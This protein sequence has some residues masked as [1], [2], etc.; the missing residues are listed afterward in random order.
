MTN[1]ATTVSESLSSRRSIRAFQDRPVDGVLLRTILEKASRSPSGGN[2]QPWHLYVIGGGR[3]E[4]LK[5]VM[6]ERLKQAPDGEDREYDVYP[7]NL[8][9]PYRDRR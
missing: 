6:R 5:A 2:L 7:P 4:E 1:T 9:A 8:I 3:M